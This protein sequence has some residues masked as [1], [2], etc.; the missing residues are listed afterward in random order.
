MILFS[1]FFTN[2]NFLKIK[3]ISFFLVF[4]SSEANSN[5]DLNKIRISYDDNT[6][7]LR[8]V[9]DANKKINY[10]L[11]SDNKKNTIKFDNKVLFRLVAK[12]TE[13][14]LINS[15]DA[16]YSNSLTWKF[17]QSHNALIAAV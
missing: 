12:N 15:I 9:F 13:R 6:S 8:V 5:N 4:V 14:V 2:I 10:V 3:L 1:N 17:D 11:S 16:N 7:K